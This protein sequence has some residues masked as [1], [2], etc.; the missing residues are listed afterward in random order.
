MAR[1]LF[2]IKNNALDRLL[3]PKQRGRKLTSLFSPG[4]AVLSQAM[5]AKPEFFLTGSLKH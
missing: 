1:I 4:F 2:L 5:E 3:I